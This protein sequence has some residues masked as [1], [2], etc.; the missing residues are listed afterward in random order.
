MASSM[1]EYWIKLAKQG[2]KDSVEEILNNL[3]EKMT[4]AESRYLDFALSHVNTPEGFDTIK[5]Y[6]FN[7]TQIQ[8]NYCALYFGRIHE[9]F[10]LREA[11]DK[12]LIDDKQAFSR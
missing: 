12:G 4:L 9:Y 2:T 10:I 5:Y 11:Y 8:R 7:G 1:S 6:L 3:N